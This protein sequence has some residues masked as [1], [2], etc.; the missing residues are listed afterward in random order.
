M[1]FD[2]ILSWITKLTPDKAALAL[3]FVVA[4][5]IIRVRQ[6]NTAWCW[7]ICMALGAILFAILGPEEST[8]TMLQNV[9]L[10]LVIGVLLGFLAALLALGIHSVAFKWLAD[11]YPNF[12][13]LVLSEQAEANNN[14]EPPKTP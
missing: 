2:A 8:R 12:K 11:P 10:N 13:L 14:Q 5:V 9:T 3:P 4:Y 7:P 1:D 6:L